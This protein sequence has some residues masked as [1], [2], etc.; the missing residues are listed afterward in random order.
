MKK[1]PK[2]KKVNYSLIEPPSKGRISEPYRL[3]DIVRRN[4]H[5]ETSQ[6]RIA[7]AWRI[8]T[9]PDKD[10]HLV[11][12]RC[13]KITDLQKEM[14][15]WDF[16]IVLNK[17]VW[18]DQDFTEDKK[19]ALLDHEVCHAAVAE[20]ADGEPKEDERGHPVFRCR[21]HDIEEFTDV[22]RRHRRSEKHPS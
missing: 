10:G 5:D 8:T 15:E 17:Q 3:L 6:A 11:L 1:E 4:Y 13:V 21:K 19:M 7:L 12:G 18:D 16:V 2:P 22:V 14:A 20:D 9:N